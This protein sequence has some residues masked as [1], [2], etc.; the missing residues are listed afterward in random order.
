[1][2]IAV[3][4]PTGRSYELMRQRGTY[5]ERHYRVTPWDYILGE[6]F[7]DYI[8]DRAW[9]NYPEQAQKILPILEEEVSKRV[10]N[11]NTQ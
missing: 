3:I 2:K 5:D 1:M 4:A 6:T 7:S 11:T 10:R 9:E 8:V